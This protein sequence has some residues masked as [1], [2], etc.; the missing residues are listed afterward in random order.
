MTENLIF[1]ILFLK[2]LFSAYSFFI[3]V[4]MF[5]RTSKTSE[6][7]THFTIQF[8]SNNFVYFMNLSFL[9]LKI[10]S[11]R[12]AAKNLS[13]FTNFPANMFLIGVRKNICTALFL[14]AQEVH[15]WSTSKGNVCIFLYIAVSNFCSKE[16]VRFYQ[17][18]VV[19]GEAE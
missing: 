1:R 16:V 14:D 13:Y 4:H 15:S 6:K 9:A 18:G 12:N 5:Q 7:N 11:Y 3:F 19:W 17:M 8:R 2:I 10:I